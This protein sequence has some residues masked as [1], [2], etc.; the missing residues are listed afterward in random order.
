VE[1]YL[2]L[3]EFLSKAGPTAILVGIGIAVNKGWLVLGR[4]YNECSKQRDAYKLLLDNHAD[5]LEARL[6]KYEAEREG[7]NVTPPA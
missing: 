1:A 5:K 6:D 7:R 4:E 2:P 3:I